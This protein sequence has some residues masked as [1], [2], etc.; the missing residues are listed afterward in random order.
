MKG[1][2]AKQI[3]SVPYLNAAPLTW[4]M[5]AEIVLEPP[6]QLARRLHGG[7]LSAALI[8]ITEV[9]FNPAYIVLDGFGI[10]SDGP[11]YSVVLAHRVPFEE[12]RVVDLDPASCTSV[13]LLKVL[14]AERGLS[15]E[16][17]PLVSYPKAL[18]SEAVLLIGDP[19]IEFRRQMT[20]ENLHQ[21]SASESYRIWDLGEAWRERTGLP[22]VYAAWAIRRDADWPTVSQRLER[23]YR[24][25]MASLD[26]IIEGETRFDVALRR[27][28]L[29]G[30]IRYAVGARERAGVERFGEWMTH[31]LAR[32]VFP[33][34]WKR[35]TPRS[36]S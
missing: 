20:P 35:A 33:V 36:P 8:S 19:A 27:A 30:S 11:V 31:Y 26:R 3:G 21:G 15:P 10:V 6:S 12:I 17:R 13:N 18:N 24:E 25:G 1:S 7:E 34:E 2:A 4:G 5:E 22:F 23:A 14:L 32:P 28:Y 16:F 9:L 29:G